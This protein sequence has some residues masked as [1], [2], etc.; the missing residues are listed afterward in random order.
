MT[1][2]IVTPFLGG[3]RIVDV[4][5]DRAPR[6][7]RLP[8]DETVDWIAFLADGHPVAVDAMGLGRMV[9]EQLRRRGV[10]VVSFNLAEARA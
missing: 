2:W 6:E 4:D 5:A 3:A 7:I 9:V 8:L 1:T 10:K